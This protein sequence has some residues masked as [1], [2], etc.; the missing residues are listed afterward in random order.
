MQEVAYE[1][2]WTRD[3]EELIKHWR[4]YSIV[5]SEK[6]ENAGYY[7]KVKHNW[8]GLPPI[9]IPLMMT[10]ISQLIPP[11]SPLSN[12][13]N[14]AMF[15]FSG[16]TGAV[17][18]W[19]N[20][21]EQYALHFQYSARFND[22]ITNIDTELSRQRKFRRPADVFLTEVRCKIDNLNDTAP[23]FP[24]CCSLFCVS[25]T[26]DPELRFK[27]YVNTSDIV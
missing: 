13:I 23:E 7:I 21:G 4:N 6:H 19:L 27:E 9:L 17:Y 2:P 12:P 10:F 16:I 11:T 3:I 5:M 20:L 26:E 18:K 1:E 22:I 24:V 14:G 8:F 15:L 25:S